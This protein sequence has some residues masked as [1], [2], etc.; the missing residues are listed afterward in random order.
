MMDIRA[1]HTAALRFPGKALFSR[2]CLALAAGLAAPPVSAA[3]RPVAAVRVSDFLNSIGVVSAVSRRGEDL[4]HTAEAVKYTG[5]R[6]IRAGYESDIPLADL[7]EL[8]RQAGVRFSFG[9]MSGGSDLARL[10]DGGRRLAARG[11]LLAFEGAN[12]SNNWGV[13]YQGEAGGRDKSWLAVAKLQRDLYSSVK[14]DPALKQIPVWSI[15]ENGAETDNV[16]LQFLTI[17]NGAGAV[18]PDGTRYADYANC[19]NYMIHPS[20]AGLH[21]NQT[22]VAADPSSACRVD[23]LY[24]NYGST[25]ARHFSGYPLSALTTLPKVTTETGVTIDGPFSE[26]VQALLYLSVYLDQ[27]K[28]GWKYTSIYLLRDRS[29]EAGNQSFG[30]YA[31]DYTPRQAARYLHNLTTVLAD[32]GSLKQPDTLA[33]F[34]PDQPPTV[35]DMLLQK[36]DRTFDLVVWDER[37]TGG[38]D[39][40]KVEL[41]ARRASVK[42]YDPT[43]GTTPTATN[44]NAVSVKLTLS[45]HPVVLE[46]SRRG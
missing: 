42:V 38:S 11:A 12:E 8:H 27:F 5:L 9:L 45:D 41:G 37:F 2:A 1:A 19:H 4:A 10:L 40:I 30:L 23:G 33:C 20:W 39:N 24:G 16:G 21:D 29:D 18:M 6:W 25:W 32:S 22:W 46:I 31:K 26:H 15:S 43:L 7:L 36:S 35:H 14:S 34:I 3:R 13:T 17:P 44:R 28:R